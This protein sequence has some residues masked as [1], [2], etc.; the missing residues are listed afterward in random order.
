LR[1]PREG[2]PA[3]SAIQLPREMLTVDIPT[4]V[5]W[6]MQDTALLPELVEGL[7]AYI[8]RLT[9]RRVPDASH[10]IVHEKPQLVAQELAAFLRA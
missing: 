2:E 6:G 10:W 5:L 9:V 1:P 7:D 4:L 8:P 3:A